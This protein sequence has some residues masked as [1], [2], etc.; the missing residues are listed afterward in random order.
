MRLTKF[1]CN[2]CGQTHGHRTDMF[3]FEVQV[4]RA[5]EPPTYDESIH[6]CLDCLSEAENQIDMRLSGMVFDA[7]THECQRVIVDEPKQHGDVERI[8]LE[9]EGATPEY[10]LEDTP[11]WIWSLFWNLESRIAK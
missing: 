5:Y 1:E 3:E 8:Y 4:R 9:P 7:D 11:D 10:M 2:G 6:V